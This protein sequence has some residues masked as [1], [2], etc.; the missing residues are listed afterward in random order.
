MCFNMSVFVRVC[1]QTW[2]QLVNEPIGLVCAD[3]RCGWT[4]RMKGGERQYNQSKF[5]YALRSFLDF[6][7][8]SGLLYDKPVGSSD[9]LIDCQK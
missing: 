4:D 8:R 6:I 7:L 3:E 9:C 2:L 1:C 5:C